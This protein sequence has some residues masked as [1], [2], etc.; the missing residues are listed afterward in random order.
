MTDDEKNQDGDWLALAE[1]WRSQPSSPLDFDALRREAGRR[2][3]RMLL[4]LCGEVF[5]LLIAAMAAAEFV[6]RDPGPG[7]RKWVVSALLAIA[8]GFTGWTVWARRRLWRDA[9]LDAAGMVEL[10]IARARNSLRYWRANSVVACLFWLIL[11]ALLIAQQSGYFGAS[12]ARSGWVAVA[13]NLPLV[14]LALVLERW[15]ARNLHAR[16]DVLK[17]LQVELRQ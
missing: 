13:V 1:D 8:F 9:G 12:D 11:V 4:V 5:G 2:T 16:I 6:L 10:E 14:L 17:S 15:R 7:I 3:R